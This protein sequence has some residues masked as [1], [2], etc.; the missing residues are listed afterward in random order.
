MSYLETLIPKSCRIRTTRKSSMDAA[1]NGSESATKNKA[2][3]IGLSQLS[4]SVLFV[5]LSCDDGDFLGTHNGHHQV[6][7]N[8]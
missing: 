2:R 3:D 7:G 1:C 5:L 8:G 4:R 6:L